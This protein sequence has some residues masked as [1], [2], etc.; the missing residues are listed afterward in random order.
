MDHHKPNIQTNVIRFKA[1]FQIGLNLSFDLNKPSSRRFEDKAALSCWNWL[2]ESSFMKLYRWCRDTHV[3]WFGNGRSPV[4]EPHRDGSCLVWVRFLF[5]LV[6]AWNLKSSGVFKFPAEHVF[7]L[8]LFS[9]IRLFLAPISF[10]L[11]LS[12]IMVECG[13]SYQPAFPLLRQ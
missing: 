13:H 8:L 5:G 12:S 4:C 10:I 3:L 6:N 11:I 9:V 7:N 1:Q 2:I